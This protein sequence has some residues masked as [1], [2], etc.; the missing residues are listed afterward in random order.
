MSKLTTPGS[1][2]PQSR[3]IVQRKRRPTQGFAQP[4]LLFKCRVAVE[5]AVGRDE[6][7][8]DGSERVDQLVESRDRSNAIHGNPGQRGMAV[9]RLSVPRPGY[10]PARQRANFRRKGQPKIRLFE[11]P[12]TSAFEAEYRFFEAPI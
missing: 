4:L 5:K 8:A 12:G 10:R 11:K 2:S 1:S 6:V 9:S 7:I 3:R